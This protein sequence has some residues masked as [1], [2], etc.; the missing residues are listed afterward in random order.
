MGAL[1]QEDVVKAAFQ[2]RDAL[3]HHAFALVR[4]A[5]LAEDVVQDAFIVVMRKWEEFRP[6]SS[7]FHWVREIVR[8][9]A[10]EAVRSRKKSGS[11]LDEALLAS[12]AAVMEGGVDEREAERQ[13][14][15][16]Q[17]LQRCVSHLSRGHVEILSGF[18]ARSSSCEEIARAQGR[19]A[20]AVRLILSRLRKQ[21]S[22]TCSTGSPRRRKAGSRR[23]CGTRRRRPPSSPSPRNGPSSRRRRGAR[24]PSSPR[25]SGSASLA[26]RRP[27]RPGAGWPRP[28]P[29]S[30]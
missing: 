10:L 14:L 23:C 19:S 16:A 26:P 20:N 18:Y 25:K 11:P 12:V 7:L 27:A 6:G 1:S 4:E 24:R 5:A 21:L 28:R 9:K 17:A 22:D 29:P 8:F 2:Y 30:S 3:F 13:R 15:R